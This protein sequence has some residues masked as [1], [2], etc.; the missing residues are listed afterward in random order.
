MLA[1][2]TFDDVRH[3]W[4]WILLAVASAAILLVSYAG[5]LRRA[6]RRLTWMLLLLRGAALVALFLALV[7]P[8]WTQQTTT[9]V[10]ARVAIVLD[11]SLSMSLPDP[12]GSSRYD[13]A[14]MAANRLR[15]RLHERRDTN[16]D[17]SF[18]DING[19]ALGKDLPGVPDVDRTDLARAIRG[20]GM[21]ARSEP[22]AGIVVVSDGMDNTG[23]AAGPTLQDFP[24]LADSPVPIYGVGFRALTGDFDLAVGKPKAPTSARINHEVQVIVPVSKTG[25]P[26]MHATASI[27][28]GQQIFASKPIDLPAGNGLQSV[29]L[30]L[31]PREAGPFIF[32]ATVRGA[33]AERF[34]ANNS[35][36]FPL[37]VEKDKIEVVY[38]EG[39]LRYEYKYL[40]DLLENDPDVNLTASVRQ[41][42]PGRDQAGTRLPLTPELLKKTHVLILGDVDAAYLSRAEQEAVMHWLEGDAHHGLLVLGGYQS[43]GPNGLGNSPLGALLPV[44]PA[45]QSPYQAEEPF[46]LRPTAQGLSGESP[47]FDISG[48]GVQDAAAWE[49]APPLLGMSLVQRAKP[50]AQVLAV[51]ATQKSA[52][53]PE[54]AIVVATQHYGVGRSMILTADTTWRWSRLA[55]ILGRE[56]RLY[57]RFW[58]QTIRWLAGRKQDRRQALVTVR[59]DRPEYEINKPVRIEAR[60]LP[61]TDVPLDT[62][63]VSVEITQANGKS[64]RVPVRATSASPHL[65]SGTYYPTRG[66]D[67]TVAVAL[68]QGNVLLSNETASF[69]VHGN[70]LELADARTDPELLRRLAAQTGGSYV[71]IADADRLADQITGRERHLTEVRRTALWDAPALFIFFLAA[72]TGEWL[73]RR[74]HHLV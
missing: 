23:R 57:G 29:T 61:R 28:R 33:A 15:D 8:S 25:G 74:R 58:G 64:I 70:D 55:R 5:F 34:L 40:H 71:D 7:K 16:F 24:E 36:R 68:R 41:A 42:N 22:L 54:G 37:L 39:F 73:L 21:R 38:I 4:M 53:S 63:D 66:G 65:F 20:A 45:Q 26:K 6:E 44:V 72:V 13:V 43:L 46:V 32:T 69:L 35:A 18:F 14:R 9:V 47:L 60:R 31:T 2:L 27:S 19:K 59:T 50:G 49:A 48:D 10:P 30:T 67:H 11:N 3:P 17:V 1:S 52:G 56:D 51:N 62:S 12:G